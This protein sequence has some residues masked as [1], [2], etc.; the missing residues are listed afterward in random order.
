MH[1]CASARTRSS[2]PTPDSRG[3]L[4][5]TGWSTLFFAVGL[6]ADLLLYRHGVPEHDPDAAPVVDR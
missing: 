5:R 6:V 1:F 4:P 3:L 2:R